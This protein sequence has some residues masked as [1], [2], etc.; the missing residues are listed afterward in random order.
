[1]ADLVAVMRDGLAESRHDEE[2]RAG[3]RSGVSPGSGS[4]GREEEERAASAQPPR[5][6]RAGSGEVRNG[7]ERS[8][9]QGYSGPKSSDVERS[10]YSSS[11][12]RGTHRGGGERRSVRAPSSGLAG[13]ACPPPRS[14]R[15]AGERK[16]G[17]RSSGTRLPPAS[18]LLSPVPR[19][20]TRGQW[21]MR[22]EFDLGH[23]VLQ[24]LSSENPAK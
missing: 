3:A 18:P 2:P 6:R 8:R 17:E 15:G 24:S 13:G 1:M 11:R 7:G 5:A 16:V 4:R 10:A 20:S 19:S 23:T 12:G 22:K 9:E 14:P 21:R